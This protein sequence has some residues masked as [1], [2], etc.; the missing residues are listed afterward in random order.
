MTGRIV[1]IFVS[2]LVGCVL[3][4]GPP[5]ALAQ[6]SP[7]PLTLDDAVRLYL[8]RNLD[9]EA[10]RLRVEHTRA[11]Q[12]A[13][14]LRPNPEITVTAENF[15]FH[16]PTPFS[17]IYEV[18]IAY[19]E[20]IELGGKRRL[21]SE[22]ADLTVAAAEAELADTLRRGVA[23][24]KLL[25]YETV[26]ALENVGI[27]GESLET[28]ER[29]IEYNRARFEEGVLA[30]ADLIKVRLESVQFAAALRRAELE[31]SQKTI[32]LIER[33]GESDYQN[34]TIVGELVFEPVTLELESLKAAA[35]ERRPDVLAAEAHLERAGALMSLEDARASVDLHPFLGYKRAASSDTLLFG[36]S[37][38]LPFR[39]RN[40]G[41]IARAASERRIAEAE[42]GALRNRV[43]AEVESAYRS[44][45]AAREQVRTFQDELL[46]P[47]DESQQIALVAYQEGATELLPLL[48]AQRTEAAVRQ[49]YFATLLD[50]HGSLI[51]LE[52]A[53]GREIRP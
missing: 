45:E 20:T 46:G 32:R 44:Y 50:Y 21:R 38:P 53:V 33:I 7:A 28:F 13:A 17:R 25:Y 36:V 29:L 4:P 18:G 1:S 40:Q 5:V 35:L 9:A 27:A 14:R 30:E 41:G 42:L 15:A 19:S 3:A 8:D 11:G 10:A 31:L 48:E 51:D 26:L 22:V 37:L 12:I 24:V 43:L 52:L 39:D 34:R 49:S 2:V 23:G 47:A 16:G 6:T